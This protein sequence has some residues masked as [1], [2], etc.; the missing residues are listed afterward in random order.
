MNTRSRVESALFAED[1]TC[2][3]LALMKNMGNDDIS[4]FFKVENNV[5]FNY[6][7]MVAKSCKGFKSREAMLFLPLSQFA[8]RPLPF[9]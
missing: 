1:D 6:E 9:V 8:E 5:V 4:V 7:S 2:I 3:V